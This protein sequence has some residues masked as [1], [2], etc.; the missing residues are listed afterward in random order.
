MTNKQGE[1]VYSGLYDLNNRTL[2][3]V[4]ES[5][6]RELTPSNPLLSMADPR[7]TTTGILMVD[8]KPYIVASTPIVHSDFSG[9]PQGVVI[10]G[11]YLG[12]NEVTYLA[13]L[14]KPGLHFIPADDPSL[15][16]EFLSAITPDKNRSAAVAIPLNSSQIA[17]YALIRDVYGNGVLALVI[18]EPRDIY[19]QGVSTTFQYVLIVL[20]AGLLFGVVILMIL[21]RFVLNQLSRLDN[22][23][24]SIGSSGELSLRIPE[25]GDEE[26]VSLTRS[27]NRM[28][29]K[30][31]QQHKDLSRARRDLADQNRDLEELN[32]KA[33]LYLDIYI[34]AI[35]YEILNATMVLRGY[36]ELFRKSAGENERRFADKIIGIAEKS[37]GVIRNIETISRIYKNPPEIREVDLASIIKKEMELHPGI[38]IRLENMENCTC[39]VLANDMIGV[40]FDNLFSNSVKFGG[41]DTEI[42]VRAE[43]TV[44]GLLEIS[45]SDTGPGI[46]DAMKPL[47]FDRF[48]QDR[49]K[50]SSYGLGLHIVK[51]LVESYGGTVWADDRIAGEPQ[52]GA[53]I[54]FTLR[55]A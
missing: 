47:V 15:P 39:G 14:T 5:L 17:G 18:E 40:V 3:A 7:A 46:I 13:N 25:T 6:S 1:I 20:G 53:A 19:Q 9:T 41:K 44:Q 38:H 16:P 31:E 51:M 35:T 45:V 30:I 27:L 33:N 4:P 43:T 37:A 32:R 23:I 10:M 26:V 11:R 21:D 29:D 50:R 52:K 8:K 42:T 24:K 54:R 48:M 2:L 22:G 49:R 55:P 12:T 34:D 28:L 36:A